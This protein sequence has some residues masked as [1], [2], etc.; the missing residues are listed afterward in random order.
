MDATEQLIVNG[1]DDIEA[2]KVVPALTATTAV[3]EG[4]MPPPAKAG[5]AARATVPAVAAVTAI[6]K[7]AIREA[8]PRVLS[9]SR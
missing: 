1:R 5:P 7:P 4:V 6:V 3:L 9:K 8:M 2:S